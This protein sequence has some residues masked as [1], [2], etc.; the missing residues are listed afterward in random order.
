MEGLRM[1]TIPDFVNDVAEHVVFGCFNVYKSVMKYICILF[2]P[3]VKHL[4]AKK[5]ARCGLSVESCKEPH[6]IK[7]LKE[8]D[9]YLRNAIEW[10][11]GFFEGYMDEEWTTQD[12]TGLAIR[13]MNT[14]K[15]KEILHPLTWIMSRMNLQT[16]SRAWAVG[17]GHYDIGMITYNLFIY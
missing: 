14:R 13:A 17:E 7:I 11:F 3:I 10:N 1:S 5:H 9:F 12:L 6:D 15:T 8:K 4:V 16:K 2:F